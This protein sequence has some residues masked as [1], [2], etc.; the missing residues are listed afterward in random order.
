MKKLKTFIAVSMSLICGLQV[1]AKDYSMRYTVEPD[2]AGH[3]L[4]VSLAC[5][6]RHDG[7]LRLKMPV[8]APGY[9][10]I[11]DFPKHLCD[12]NVVDSE[13]NKL[14]WH[15]ESKNLW[16]IDTEGKED[17]AV[18]YRI[19]ANERNVAS[20]R[21]D[22]KSAFIA[23]NGVFMYVDGDVLHPVSVTYSLP[24]GWRN[25][26]TGLKEEKDD[27]YTFTASDFDV[28]YDSPVL[29]GNH[30]V[31][32]FEHEGRDY[33]FAIETPE[34]IEESGFEDCFR[35]IVSECNK[36]MG[37]VPYDKYALI[38]LG[39]GGGGLEHINSQACYTEGTYKFDSR[40]EWL[41]F[42]AFVAHEYFHL[43]NVKT[44]RPIELGPFDYDKE[45][46][47]PLIWFSE[48]ITCYYECLLLLRAGLATEEEIYKLLSGYMANDEPYEGKHHQSLRMTSYDI[49]LNFMNHD[50]NSKDVR[51]N[52]YFRG[53][54]VG[55]I[56]DIEIKRLSGGQRSLDDLMRLLY[57][58]FHKEKGRGFTEEEFWAAV[59][60]VAGGSMSHVRYLVDNPV[61]IDYEKY[62]TPAGLTLDRE[63]WL[64]RPVSAK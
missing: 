46:Y 48:G 4:N 2:T 54:V 7:Q 26:S 19:F 50:A 9:Y 32:K 59:D 51:I 42:L 38:H 16:V 8:W 39:K 41:N 22:S 13:G 35:A 17:V 56:M 10:E 18:T 29:I 55:L 34:G 40:D 11:L 5:S 43:Y 45:A 62:L 37:D 49:W 28:L 44:I 1:S 57:N 33:E 53:P 58:R 64:I 21:V 6:G 27:P 52:Y 36:M 14:K 47:S 31:K 60:E 63:K 3:Y 20:S 12:F 23:P 61:E 30:Y 15:K 24:S 25:I